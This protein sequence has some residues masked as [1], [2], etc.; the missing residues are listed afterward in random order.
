MSLIDNSYNQKPFLAIHFFLAC[1][2]R[3]SARA[4][5]VVRHSNTNSGIVP[6]DQAYEFSHTYRAINTKLAYR[7]R[8]TGHNCITNISCSLIV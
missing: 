5:G 3:S 8:H 1:R 7:Q 4:F 2:Y 6:L